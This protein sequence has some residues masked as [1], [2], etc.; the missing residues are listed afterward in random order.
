MMQN[1]PLN[2]TNQIKTPLTPVQTEEFL[3]DGVQR[4][5]DISTILKEEDASVANLNDLMNRES[6][7]DDENLMILE[8]SHDRL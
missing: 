1:S 2:I 6:F 3:L 5:S 7:A 8:Q 4:I